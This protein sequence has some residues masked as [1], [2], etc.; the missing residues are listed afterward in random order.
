MMHSWESV[1]ESKG[2]LD[3]R[4]NMRVGLVDLGTNSVRYDIYELGSGGKIKT[5]HSNKEMIRLGHNVFATGKLDPKAVRRLLRSFRDY[6]AL[7]ED[8]GVERIAAFATSAMRE[9]R[10]GE[11]V[12]KLIHHETGIRVRVISGSEEAR[13]IALGVQRNEKRCRGNYT[14]IDIGGGSTELIVCRG[15]RVLVRGSLKLGVA[16]LQ[17]LY[18]KS[19]PPKHVWAA[20]RYFAKVRAGSTAREIAKY[21]VDRAIGSSGTVKALAKILK[22]THGESEILRDS[23]GELRKDMTR[24]TRSQLLHIPGMVERRVDLI[25]AGALILEE[26]MDLVGA[27]SVVPTPFALRDGLLQEVLKLKTR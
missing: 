9:A 22:R 7:T 3:S 6:R 20:D 8:F 11:R 1:V 2:W 24:K 16:R 17:E 18:L 23:L 19:V 13:L 4:A 12:K 14:L 27:K 10:D 15:Q 25:L 21:R 26:C 5:L